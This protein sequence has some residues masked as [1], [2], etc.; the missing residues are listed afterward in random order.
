MALVNIAVNKE[1]T[2]P[3]PSKTN[4][5][6]LGLLSRAVN[7]S[8]TVNSEKA[9]ME[10][11]YENMFQQGRETWWL[12]TTEEM[13]EAISPTAIDGNK[14]LPTT[15]RGDMYQPGFDKLIL[16]PSPTM[17]L[18]TLVYHVTEGHVVPRNTMRAKMFCWQP[19]D[20]QQRHRLALQIINFFNR[21][22]HMFTQMQVET[23]KWYN[24]T[25]DEQASS[26]LWDIELAANSSASNIYEQMITT[27][28]WNNGWIWSFNNVIA[29]KMIT[30]TEHLWYPA[31]L[32]ALEYS[33][34]Q[35]IQHVDPTLQKQL[36][37][38][39]ALQHP[40]NS[41]MQ[42]PYYGAKTIERIRGNSQLWQHVMKFN[43]EEFTVR[44][45]EYHGKDSNMGVNVEEDDGEL[46]KEYD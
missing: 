9:D 41:G 39:L 37:D 8:A 20:V 21:G 32:T 40:L 5:A 43:F 16:C 3:M 29:L 25:M 12:C 22:Y 36:H 27:W 10:Q 42:L 30:N 45:N 17:A 23:N 28:S 6:P 19:N 14:N 33:G 44:F 7:M 38:L 1:P 35:M 31:L 2:V 13:W 24:F 15:L 4:M 46:N 18:T 11:F 34:L 26:Q